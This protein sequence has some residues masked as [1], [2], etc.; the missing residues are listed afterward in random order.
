VGS[1]ANF[2]SDVWQSFGAVQSFRLSRLQASATAVRKSFFLCC[3]EE[4]LRLNCGK[5]TIIIWLVSLC[6]SFSMLVVG[7]FVYLSDPQHS[8]LEKGQVLSQHPTE[9]TLFYCL[10]L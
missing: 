8:V 3:G 4:S 2:L 7:C 6:L 9:Q 1:V 5:D 10:F